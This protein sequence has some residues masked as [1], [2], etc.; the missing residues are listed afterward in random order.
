MRNIRTSIDVGSSSL[1]MLV[2]GHPDR[3]SPEK[4]IALAEAQTDGM[5]QGYI[6]DPNLV[7]NAI[8]SC[9][10]LCE[11]KIGTKINK[12]V[13]GFS[14]IGLSS[15]YTVGS[16]IITRADNTVSES[17]LSMAIFEGEGH[18][19]LENK[20]IIHRIPIEYYLDGV[21]ILGTPV[22]LKGV[23]LEVKILL[24]TAMTQHL[25]TILS[26]VSRSGIEVV[27]VIA[28]PLATASAILNEKQKSVGTGVI[29]IGAET[30]SGAVYENGLP[31]SVFTIPVGSNSIT[32]DIAIFL[33]TD[34]E[35]AEKIK[36]GEIQPNISRR[37]LEDIIFARFI[38]FFE[39]T[40]KQLKKIKR[41]GLLPGGVLIVGRGSLINGIESFA[42]DILKLPSKV[43]T[44]TK[45]LLSELPDSS[46]YTAYGLLHNN[47][48]VEN[49]TIDQTEDVGVWQNIKKG[50]KNIISQLLP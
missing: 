24:V 19:N 42:K 37:K 16:V 21:L 18:A 32:K 47:L 44:E 50:W 1:R 12:A 20:K 48:N 11:E 2:F 26:V 40:D 22:G 6:I 10:Q 41:S 45:G 27:D 25:E 23:K 13:I 5:R 30:I 35:E 14:G 15:T 39:L 8:T 9:K 49:E 31:I 29:D 36:L 28:S 43:Y 34:Y 4:I 38:D 17:D 33:R 3:K 7:K 46:W